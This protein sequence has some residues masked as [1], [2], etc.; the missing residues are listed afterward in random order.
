MNGIRIS[1]LSALTA[2][3]IAGCGS[4]EAEP[5]ASP[6]FR[7]DG[8]STVYPISVEAARR[9]KRSNREAVIDVR[10][11]GSTGGFRR[12]CAGEIEISDASRP[13]NVEEI[14]TCAANGVRFIELPIGF[15]ALS[16]VVHPDNDWARE[17]TVEEL[18]H[19]WEPAA[20]GRVTTWKAVR[21]EWPDEPIRLFGPGGDSG[22]YDYFT[23]AIV[24]EARRSRQDYTAS[25]DDD[26][27]VEGVAADP[28]A[29]GFFGFGYYT[30]NWE[31]LS[32]LA[33]DA[34]D[35]P[36]EP[37]LDSARDGSY[38]PLSRPLFLY[39]NADATHNRPGLREYVDSAL[40][41][42]HA[43]LPLIGYMPLSETHY[44]RARE[45]FAQGNTGSR[46]DGKIAV[47]LAMDDL[48]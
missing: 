45:R 15:D 28:N 16:V 47:G 39:V 41:G 24:G 10:F 8:S 32:V 7:I 21:E 5:S 1:L 36:V 35:G 46:F 31:M 6:D 48:L 40:E 11:S 44:V 25:E 23:E 22:T 26:E 33:V 12:F 38:Q 20:D 17:I 34:G 3:V 18:R 13:I 4:S 19:L 14:A 37:S 29:L 42:M 2:L 27:L 30:R 43:W 9:Y